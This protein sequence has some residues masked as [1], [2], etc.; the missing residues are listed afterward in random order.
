MFANAPQIVVRNNMF[1]DVHGDLH[2]NQRLVKYVI[3]ELVGE[4][5]S[6]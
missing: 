6:T 2:L 5:R 1:K 3:K 4:P